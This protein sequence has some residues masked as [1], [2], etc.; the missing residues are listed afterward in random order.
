MKSISI[1]LGYGVFTK[2]QV[3]YEAYL[4]R[5]FEIVKDSDLII[6]C[7]GASNKDYPELTEAESMASLFMEID[8]SISQKIFLE[9]ESFSTPQSIEFA[10]RYLISHKLFAE[11]IRIICDSCRA[12]KAFYTALNCL[13]PIFGRFISEKDA[14]RFLGQI[15]TTIPDLTK[16]V[17]F[18]NEGI[19]V[20]G[21]PLS[22]SIEELSRQIMSS[23]IEVNF[24]RYPELHEE[25]IAFR[26]KQWGIN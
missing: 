24:L 20:H 25:F 10:A 15:A 17:D 8:P 6:T 18:T 9:T 26:K 5:T 22:T 12:P 14:T 1:V 7:A 2:G 11:N 13:G 4:R 23:M 3:E 21:I 19:S 16:E